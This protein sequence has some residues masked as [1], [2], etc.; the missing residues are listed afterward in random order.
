MLGREQILAMV[1]HQY[2]MCLWDE[3]LQWDADSVQ[4]R[5]SNHRH[6]DHPLRRN[7][8]LHAIHLC[9]YGAQAMAVHGGL[10][11]RSSGQPAQP[12]MLVSLRDVQLHIARLDDLSG[13]LV[14]TAQ[15]LVEAP[16][17][18]QYV[19][20]IHHGQQLI[21]SGRAAVMLQLPASAPSPSKE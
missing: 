5:A 20:H 11:A 4:V 3:V 17:S 15:V 10:R 8:Q 12:G 1:P 6:D 9:E 7:G 19:F 13:D 18:Q 14:A 21:A 2:G 16:G